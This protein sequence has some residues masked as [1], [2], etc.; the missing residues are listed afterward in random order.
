MD[1]GASANN[2]LMQFQSDILNVR[3]VRPSVIE[4]TA[5]GAAMM[6]GLAT[7]VWTVADLNELGGIDRE[8]TPAMDEARRARL[9]AHWKRAVDRARSWAEE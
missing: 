6:A 7:G 3:T 2:F 5:K 8:F 1:G 4:T 9:L